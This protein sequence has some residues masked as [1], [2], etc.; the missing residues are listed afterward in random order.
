MLLASFT[1]VMIDFQNL[2]YK[3]FTL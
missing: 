2:I 1:G 3:H